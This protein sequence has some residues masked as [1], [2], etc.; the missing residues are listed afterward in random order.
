M[1][2]IAYFFN[3]LLCALIIA[4]DVCYIIFGETWLKGITSG[5]FVLLALINL[6]ASIVLKQGRLKFSIFL[7]IGLI[8]AM[9]GDIFLNIHF[10]TGAVLFA[11]GHVFF[12]ISYCNLVRFKW[13]DLI[14][15][16]AIFVPSMLFILLAPMFNFGSVLMEV[17]CILYALIISLMVGK[18]VINLV[19]ER[20]LLNLI[21]VFG[22][23]LFF[24]S[25]LMLLLNVFG[26]LP[27]IID[28][29]CLATYYPAEF[30][31]A[32]SIIAPV[33][34]RKKN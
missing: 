1:K 13:Q 30:L 24:F 15:G 32:H 27:R 28:V 5:A 6:I 7:F 33:L 31:L 34:W 2:R 3:A 23:L 21:I 9:L 17:V 12:F 11:V 25:D 29:L 18:A 10:I 22:S 20:S 14:A 8:F 4:G 16:L 19:A 26:G